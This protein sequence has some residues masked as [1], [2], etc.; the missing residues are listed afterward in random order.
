MNARHLHEEEGGEH[1][2]LDAASLGTDVQQTGSHFHALEPIVDKINE[3]ARE[4]TGRF[5]LF[6][7]HKSEWFKPYKEFTL[8]HE[9]FDLIFLKAKIAVLCTKGFEIMDINKCAS[10]TLGL[11]SVLITI[12]FPGL[13]A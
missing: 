5:G 2:L 8:P 10:L 4:P 11:V 1:F 12:S 7:S 13:R 9:S 6:R 3:R